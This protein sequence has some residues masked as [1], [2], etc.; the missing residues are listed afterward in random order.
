[1]PRSIVYILQAK[2]HYEARQKNNEPEYQFDLEIA[3]RMKEKLI[4][5]FD[6]P[7]HLASRAWKF[8]SDFA[9]DYNSGKKPNLRDL[10]E[11]VRQLI[12]KQ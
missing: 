10:E 1:M 2:D 8:A 9:V 6:V 3:K 4:I 5:A 12:Q 11:K 7:P